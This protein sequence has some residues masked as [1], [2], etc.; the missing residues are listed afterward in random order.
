MY[1]CATLT[2]VTAEHMKSYVRFWLGTRFS[3]SSEEE[4]EEQNTRLV[5]IWKWTAHDF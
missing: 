5:W 3:E 1:M 4:M 2:D